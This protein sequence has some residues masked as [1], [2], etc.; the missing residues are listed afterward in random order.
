LGQR[1]SHY[2]LNAFKADA[3]LQWEIDEKQPTYFNDFANFPDEGVSARHGNGAT[4]ACFGGSAERMS[5]TNFY[6]LAGGRVVNL[7]DG[8]RSWKK[9]PI[10]SLPN[11]LWCAP[12]VRAL[13]YYP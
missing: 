4:V 13:P 3:F 2:K 9:L 5:V 12:S 7:T 11:R 10:T 6:A 8:G 1:E